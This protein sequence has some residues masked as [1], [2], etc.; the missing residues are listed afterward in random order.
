MPNARISTGVITDPPPTPVVPTSSPTPRPKRT[1][2]GS[3]CQSGRAVGRHRRPCGRRHLLLAVEAALDL[4]GAR[5]PA[6]A[7]GGG[8]GAVRAADRL[9]PAIVQRVVWHVVGHDVGPD[10]GLRPVGERAHLPQTVAPVP[11]DLLRRGPRRALV[12]A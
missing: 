3:M 5:P 7:A 2:S 11:A 4:V 8:A 6:V 12:A 1:I 10:L 9:V